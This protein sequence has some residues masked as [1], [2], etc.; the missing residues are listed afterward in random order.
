VLIGHTPIRTQLTWCQK[1]GVP[2]AI[3]T[4]FGTE[5]I[6]GD[7]EALEA[8]IQVLAQERGVEVEMARDGMEMTVV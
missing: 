3:F 2:R 1:E 5:L 8:R 7:E 4:H 6:E